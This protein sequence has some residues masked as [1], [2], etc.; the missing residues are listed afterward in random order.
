MSFRVVRVLERI[1]AWRGY[2]ENRMN[3]RREFTFVA[4]AGWADIREIQFEFFKPGLQ[5][6]NLYV[7]RSRG[8]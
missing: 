2:P 3:N 8:Y 5:A 1:V 4:L 7:E 6:Q